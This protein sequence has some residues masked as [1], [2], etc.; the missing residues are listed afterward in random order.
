MQGTCFE[1]Y[2]LQLLLAWGVVGFILKGFLI[3]EAFS[4]LRIEVIEV[5]SLR[6]HTAHPLEPFVLVSQ[7]LHNVAFLDEVLSVLYIAFDVPSPRFKQQLVD[8]GHVDKFALLMA[9]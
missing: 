6:L 1:G 7:R 8:F 3:K 2:F 4:R 5:H 9:L